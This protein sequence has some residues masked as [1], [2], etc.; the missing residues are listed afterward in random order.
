MKEFVANIHIHSVYSDGVKTPPEIA[1]DAAY[2]GID[3]IM[4]TDHNVFPIGFNGYYTFENKN[5]LIITGEEI[6]DQLRH[7]QKNHLL[8]LGIKKD[9]SRLAS[10]PQELINTINEAGGLSFI[11]HAY[12]PALPAIGEADLSWVD[13]SVSGFTGLELWNNLSELKIRAQK[14][15]QV[16]LYAFFPELMALEPPR[17]ISEIWDCLL[18]K[19]QRVIA[20]GGADAHT[21][22]R[23]FGPFTKNVFPYSYH[24][25]TINNHILLPSSLTGDAQTDSESIIN[26]IR[27]GHC[28]IGYDLIK[29]TRNFRFYMVDMD[30]TVEMG[31]ST[32]FNDHQEFIAEIPFPTQCRLIKDGE[33]IDQLKVNKSYSWK[34]RQPGVYRLECYRKFLGKNRGWIFSNPIFINKN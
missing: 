33:V 13:W 31:S 3:I 34:V 10:N 24:F 2:A 9:F 16:V 17:Q 4:V 14:M 20:I 27:Q 22:P 30:A 25:R 19:G 15:W 23:H 8:A 11:A 7:P 6:H 18:C 21:I 28:F 1:R 5:V 12:D 29:P 32:I 26:A